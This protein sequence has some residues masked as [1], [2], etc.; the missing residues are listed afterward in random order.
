M[1]LLS[2]IFKPNLRRFYLRFAV[3][4][5]TNILA[6]VKMILRFYIIIFNASLMFNV[7]ID[8][9]NYSL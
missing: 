5:L 8:S 6:H 3:V 7:S 9:S 2:L 1:Y 4:I